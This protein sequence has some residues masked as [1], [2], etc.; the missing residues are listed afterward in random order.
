MKTEDW[1]GM[2]NSL[3]EQNGLAIDM[4]TNNGYSFEFLENLYPK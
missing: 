2:Q 1:S 4:K 3:R